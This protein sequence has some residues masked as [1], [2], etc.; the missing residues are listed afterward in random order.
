MFV[1]MLNFQRINDYRPFKDLSLGVFERQKTWT[2]IDQ[3]K[4]NP[5]RL[6]L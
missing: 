1:A 5:L 4:P 3:I 2:V 6:N